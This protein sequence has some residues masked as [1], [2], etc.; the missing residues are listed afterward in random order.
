MSRVWILQIAKIWLKEKKNSTKDDMSRYVQNLL[1][2]IHILT[3]L[4][5]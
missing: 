2:L 1:I 3:G 4:K 5:G